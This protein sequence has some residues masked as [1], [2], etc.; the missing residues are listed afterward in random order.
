MSTE[1]GVIATLKTA[2]PTLCQLAQ[3]NGISAERAEALM[4]QEIEFV[5]EAAMLNPKIMQSAPASVLL[6]VK[7]AIKN[8]LTLDPQAGLMYIKT[9][10]INVSQDPNAAQWITIMETQETCNGLLSKNRMLGRILDHNVPTVE[11]HADGKVKSVTFTFQK[12]TGNWETMTYSDYDFERWGSA[13]HKERSRG[14]NDANSKNYANALYSSWRGGIDP[15]FAKAKAIRHSLKKLG[16]NP[17]ERMASA[18]QI[19][20][21]DFKVIEP[22][23]ANKEADDVMAENVTNDAA[24]TYHITT[25]EVVS[26][27]TDN[28]PLTETEELPFN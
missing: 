7:R 20:P 10:S 11:F 22:S 9:R 19:S 13:S 14:K 25:H 5:R 21:A 28:T 16:T 12:N 18:I 17:N 27:P 3:I 8:N 2:M 24:A 1:T 6:A 23:I 4:S 26:V 15:E